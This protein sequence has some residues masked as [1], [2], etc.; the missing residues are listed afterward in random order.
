MLE[1]VLVTGGLD[2][3]QE[4]LDRVFMRMALKEAV[5]AFRAGEVPVGA[6]V[7]AGGRV[8]CSAHNLCESR[9]D[10]TAHAEILALRAACRA[11][12]NYRL[13]GAWV[14]VSVEPCVMCA[15]ALHWARVERVVYG[16]SDPKAGA[17]GSMYTIHSDGRLNHRLQVRG[18]VLGE[19]CGRLMRA[20]FKRLR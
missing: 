2:S 8:L 6:V 9:C 19:E 3:D 4:T 15:G 14:Y 1:G 17:M 11:I 7:V 5:A 10:P 18:G 12:G 13:T 20:F 16:C